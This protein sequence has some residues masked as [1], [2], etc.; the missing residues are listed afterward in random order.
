MIKKN[1]KAFICGIF[2]VNTIVTNVHSAELLT[3]T[4][5][6]SEKAQPAVITSLLKAKS[7]QSVR[8]ARFD[9]NLLDHA[10]G[11]IE[12]PDFDGGSK[13]FY[14]NK[15]THSDNEKY[16]VWNGD[17]EKNSTREN[18]SHE[19]KR[20]LLNQA[21]LVIHGTSLAGSYRIDGQL[22]QL[23][24]LK[25]SEIAIVKVNESMIIDTD[26]DDNDINLKAV[27]CSPPG[28]YPGDNNPVSTIRVAIVTT[29]ET[30]RALAGTDMDALV[31]L[32]F[33]E[34]NQAATN[35]DVGIHFE[36]AGVLDAEFVEFGTY[37]EMRKKMYANSGTWLGNQIK[38]FR[39]THKADLAVLLAEKASENGT[40]TNDARKDNAFSVVNYRSCTGAYTFS[41]EMGHNIGSSHDLD[42]YGGVPK[43]E[44]CYRHGYKH[45]SSNP[46]QRWRTVM[47]YQCKSG[48]CPR[49]NM[50]SNPRLTYNNIPLGSKEYEDNARRLN[51]RR[52]T[53]AAFYP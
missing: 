29:D 11:S 27:T 42:Q 26:A 36:N 28:D 22:Y 50:F 8:F 13:T 39:D 4:E 31:A 12:L 17:G 14:R 33:E 35:S 5:K 1:T 30:R 2:L 21:T 3:F 25:N 34:A 46:T 19:V 32:A 15:I 53:V 23:W 41:H 40:G 45:E 6:K 24:P 10:T 51:E 20:D 18:S 48:S 37:S 43:R 7:T 44:P 49:V 47:S 9:I 52:E 16:L 38:Q